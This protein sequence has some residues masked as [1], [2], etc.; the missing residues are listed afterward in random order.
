MSRI[1]SEEERWVF[2]LY[3][4]IEEFYRGEKNKS[5]MILVSLD[6]VQKI[7][8]ICKKKVGKTEPKNKNKDIQINNYFQIEKKN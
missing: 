2:I 4:G 3:G 5:K 1:S 7:Q 6:C 8:K